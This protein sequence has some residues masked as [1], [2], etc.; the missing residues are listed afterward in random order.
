M[1]TEDIQKLF[2]AFLD[3]PVETVV[4]VFVAILLFVFANYLKAYFSQ[5]GKQHAQSSISE[6]PSSSDLSP[7]WNSLTTELQAII[8]LAASNAEHD[9]K[10]RIS[11]R[12]FFSSIA[13]I[14]PEGLEQFLTK[15]PEGAMPE[16]IPH[17]VD[18]NPKSIEH[19]LKYSACMNESVRELSERRKGEMIS[20]QDMFVDIAKNGKGESVRRLR[21]HGVDAEVI[22]QIVTQMGWQLIQRSETA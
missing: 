18:A 22:E 19:V 21:T 16:P 6:I 14:K 9:L 3:N 11:T 15:L 7:Y 2:Q 17:E 8:M 12:D 4:V 5:K 1:T 13:S 20:A 10:D